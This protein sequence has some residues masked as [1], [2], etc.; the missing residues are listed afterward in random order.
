MARYVWVVKAY[1][2][3]DGGWVRWFK[4]FA[5]E[6]DAWMAVEMF[7]SLA[8]LSDDYETVDIVKTIAFH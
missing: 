6:R 4:N 7:W 5:N 1:S 8:V 2:P 3:R